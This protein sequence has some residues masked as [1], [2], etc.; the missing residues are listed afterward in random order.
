MQELR[1]QPLGQERPLEEEMANHSSIL[2]WETPWT[3]ECGRNSAWSH[4]ESDM[5]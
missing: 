2:T 1:V 5:T 3:E 4:E